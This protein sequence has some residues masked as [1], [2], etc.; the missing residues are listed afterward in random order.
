MFG[1]FGLEEKAAQ[2]VV[3]VTS[4]SEC[5]VVTELVGRP[6]RTTLVPSEVC[7]LLGSSEPG[8]ANIEVSGLQPTGAGL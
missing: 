5:D 6:V 3:A 2:G 4:A 7:G 8:T 1:I